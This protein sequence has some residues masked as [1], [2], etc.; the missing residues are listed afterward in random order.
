MCARSPDHPVDAHVAVHRV[1]V[2][3]T[4]VERLRVEIAVDGRERQLRVGPG[5]GDRDVAGDG[6]RR[7][8]TR[9]VPSSARLPLHA[10]AP[11]LRLSRSSRGCRRTPCADRPI[12][13]A[14]TLMSNSTSTPPRV[15]GARCARPAA[16]RGFR[17][18]RLRRWRRRAAAWPVR[19]SGPTRVS[20]PAPRSDRRCPA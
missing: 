18:H 4:R 19:H 16:R 11:A 14:G 3:R 8:A 9:G 10:S 20:A 6:F 2:E 1:E 7:A 13:S 15:S 12:A 17:W 5:V